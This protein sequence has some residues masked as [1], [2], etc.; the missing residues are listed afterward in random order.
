MEQMPTFLQSYQCIALGVAIVIFLITV[1]LSARRMIGW[2]FTIILLII[3]VVTSLVIS[4]QHPVPSQ[5]KSLE[6]SLQP[7]EEGTDFK[8]HILQAIN[9]IH[10]ELNQEKESLKKVSEGM[11]VLILQ[12][13]AQKQKLQSFIEEAK[14][15]FS[16]LNHEPEG[17]SPQSEGEHVQI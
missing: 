13:D 5:T 3:T 15:K 17:H 14:E 1:F 4:H 16:K 11:Q 2:V 12:M 7:I 10:I 6:T 9:H 8:E